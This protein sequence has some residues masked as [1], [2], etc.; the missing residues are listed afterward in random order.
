MPKRIYI[1]LLM[2]F[3]L[4]ASAQTDG[5]RNYTEENPLVYE[6]CCDLWPYAFLN[7]EGKPE[8]Y[9]IALVD[10][11]M[12]ELNIPYV[13][14][15]KPR[16]ET[17]RDLKEGKADLTLGLAAGFHD[18]YGRYGRH[19]IT[20]FTQSVATAKGKP[21]EIKS[22]RDL[23]KPGI[24][25]IVNDSSLCHHLMLDYGWEDHVVV[26][27]D[28]KAALHEISTKKE[29]QIV[30]NT[31]SLKWLI[32][33]ENIDNVV[34][35]PVNMPHGDYKFIANDQHL[36]DRLDAAYAGLYTTG[37]ITELQ[38]KWFYPDYKGRPTPDWVWILTGIATL[39]LVVALI[40]GIGYWLQYRK[41][42]R[43]HRKLNRRLALIIE[44]SKVRIWTY[45]V[46]E[47]HFAWHN[48][49][50]QI[51]HTYTMT[52]F[53]DR[54][55]PTDFGL[56]KD[57]L[58]RLV[59]QHRDAKGREEKEIT[60]DLRAMDSEDGDH[61][62]RNFHIVLSVLERDKHGKP[63]IIIGTKKDVTE[64]LRLK[65]LEDNRTLRYWSIFYS[66]EAAI[67]QFDKDGYVQDASPKACEIF[68]SESDELINRHVHINDMLHTD[69]TD[70]HKTDG[71]QGVQA[72]DHGKVECKMKTVYNDE[73]E[74]LS[75]FAFCRKVVAML[76][77]LFTMLPAAA[78]N[79]SDRYNSQRPVVIVCNQQ[80]PPYE[81][82]NDNR[83][84]A[85]SN[86]DVMKAVLDELGLPYRFI[87]RAWSKPKD[88]FDG[89]SADLI[90]AD[91]RQFTGKHY[92]ISDNV[93]SYNRVS[94]DSIAEIHFIGRDRQLIEQIDD[95][96]SRLKQSGEITE[97]E[98]SWM[99]PERVKPDYSKVVIYI[100]IGV[101]LLAAILYLLIFLAR[102]HVK[103]MTHNSKELNDMMSKALH[104]GNYDVMVY[105]I[106][107]RHITN[108]YGNIL[109]EEGMTP[110]EYVLRIHPNQREEFVK[111]SKSLLEGRERHFD[112]NKRW[113]SGTE[114]APR[115][116][117]FQGHSISETDEN[118]R[119]AYIINAVNDVTQ[120]V[121]LYRAAR[122]I[123]HKYNAILDDPFVAM[124]F[125]DDKGVLIDHNDAMK[126]MLSGIEDSLFK[127]VF[128]PTERHDVRCTRHLYYPEYGI[129]K[130][131]ECHIQPLYNVNGEIANY[132][133]T[134]TEQ[135]GANRT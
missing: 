26:S 19:A 38:D 14:K 39:L 108:L 28:M 57:A 46:K 69:F 34:L 12:S 131:V 36:L 122:N 81:F 91:D 102:R 101:L 100:A 11:L 132:L 5:E 85:G 111:K 55:L 51:V 56:L 7:E 35:T 133:V 110:E 50:G 98:N 4:G 106:A 78:Q 61:E 115:Y 15:L 82:M 127:E 20:L 70:M 79:L 65:R 103:I 41:V 58:Y 87:L 109:P 54:Y 105:D 21:V 92:F 124:S 123:V 67:L 83:Q 95:Q 63:T 76:I 64:K 43:A 3:S 74:L 62:L 18:E 114:E 33:H 120:E 84:L 86:I 49:N 107:K 16:L 96:F 30:W 32:Q 125:Y 112:L 6:D 2:L 8:G 119:L 89:S 66:Q 22:F 90:M 27:K 25:V 94:E 1:L 45:H 23:G 71:Y 42:T 37:E 134:T 48:D 121:A 73:G 130:F 29:G 80:N 13:I 118:G 17:F 97:I 88:A 129:D 93:I 126:K 52:D 128:K 60:L 53:S 10:R 44:T 113:N 104:M 77:L 116:L 135:T 72:V 40:Y 31:L 24:K 47:Q 99:H 59:S 68:H 117:D 9:N 75:V